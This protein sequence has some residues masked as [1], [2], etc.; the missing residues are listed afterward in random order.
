MPGGHDPYQEQRRVAHGRPV[1]RQHERS[2]H[3]QERTDRRQE[4]DADHGGALGREVARAIERAGEVQPQH[5]APPVR[6]ERL[7]R[8]QRREERERAADEEGVLPVRDQLVDADVLGDDGE[9]STEARA[10][11]NAIASVIAGNTLWRPPRPSR[12]PALR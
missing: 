8:E 10:G 6:A 9:K 3:E 5:A 7:W 11:R 4:H 1:S 12:V 2:E